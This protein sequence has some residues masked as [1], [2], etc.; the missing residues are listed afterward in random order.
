MVECENWNSDGKTLP[1]FEGKATKTEIRFVVPVLV[2]FT[3]I[4]NMKK[5]W[6]FILWTG[7]WLI[8]A[9]K[10]EVEIWKVLFRMNIRKN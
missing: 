5:W 9:R 3:T 1:Q 8:Y 4:T 10:L 7:N 6:S 2:H